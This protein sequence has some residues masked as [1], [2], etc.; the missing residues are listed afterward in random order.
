MLSYIKNIFSILKAK[1]QGRVLKHISSW[2]ATER[3][4]ADSTGLEG[5]LRD[6]QNSNY[7][8]PQRSGIIMGLRS[9]KA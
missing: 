3:A 6:V 5:Q 2:W 9:L 8:L 4:P 7:A 1:M